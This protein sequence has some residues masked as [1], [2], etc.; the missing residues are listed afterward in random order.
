MLGAAAVC[1]YQ[2]GVT[3]LLFRS[4]PAMS[5]VGTASLWRRWWAALEVVKVLGEL[6]TTCTSRMNKQRCLLQATLLSEGI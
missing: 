5:D 4:C 3:E 1:A 6:T 2:G